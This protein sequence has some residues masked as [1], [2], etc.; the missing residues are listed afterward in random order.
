MANSNTGCRQARAEAGCSGSRFPL[1]RTVFRSLRAHREPRTGSNT[2]RTAAQAGHPAPGLRTSSVRR[3]LHPTVTEPGRGGSQLR[4][5]GMRRGGGRSA[6]QGS[7]EALENSFGACATA[8]VKR[9][10]TD[11]WKSG[12]WRDGAGALWGFGRRG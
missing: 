6:R 12:A 5:L 10:K 3:P 1:A 4:E 2:N 9:P 8:A 7:D 11:V